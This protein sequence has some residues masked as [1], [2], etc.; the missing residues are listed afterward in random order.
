MPARREAISEALTRTTPAAILR[1]LTQLMRRRWLIVV[2]AAL[3]LLLAG[4][5]AAPVCDALGLTAAASTIRTTY[6][7]L[8]P[9]R[10]SH[11]YF[12]LGYQVALEQR[13]LAIFA[14]QLAC[15]LVYSAVRSRIQ[16]L[17]SMVFV[18]VSLPLAWDV[19][20]QSLGVRDSDWVARTWTGALFAAAS[21]AW[22]YPRFD[23]FL[24][25]N[26]HGPDE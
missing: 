15:G 26:A 7:W 21:V 14:V 3:A 1:D 17:S 10:P 4:A 19:L 11:S 8:C 5:L 12:V 13:M 24:P 25:G 2:N 20:S 23:E 6:L 18:L 16:P 22:L 9:Q